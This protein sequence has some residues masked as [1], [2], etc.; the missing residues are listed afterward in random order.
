LYYKGLALFDLSRYN[1]AIQYFDQ[2]LSVNPKDNDAAKYKELAIDKI[3]KHTAIT[4]NEKDEGLNKLMREIFFPL[5]QT[6]LG[7]RISKI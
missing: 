4:C 7:R 2:S 5:K 1:E 6:T 3:R